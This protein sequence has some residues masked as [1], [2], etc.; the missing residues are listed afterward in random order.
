[1]SIRILLQLNMNSAGWCLLVLCR[2]LKDELTQNFVHIH[3]GLPVSDS[4]VLSR[5]FYLK[6]ARYQTRLSEDVNCKGSEEGHTVA[7]FNLE[8]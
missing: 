6:V 7:L 5:E 8:E 1:M 4:T 3:T 2:H